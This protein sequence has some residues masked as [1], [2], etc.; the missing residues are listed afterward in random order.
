M[1]TLNSK[2]KPAAFQKYVQTRITRDSEMT[3]YVFGSKSCYIRPSGGHVRCCT[4]KA[5][6]TV[7]N[8]YDY[9]RSSVKHIEKEV[10]E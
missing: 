9:K 10:D 7:V 6:V 5:I 8:P 2:Y 4:P 1:Q 3:F